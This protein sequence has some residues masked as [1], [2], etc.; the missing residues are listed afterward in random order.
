MNES[1]IIKTALASVPAPIA[2]MAALKP[3]PRKAAMAELI[4]MPVNGSGSA[5]NT[6]RPKNSRS[7]VRRLFRIARLAR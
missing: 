4:H 5:A 6:K 2:S 1:I 3:S 7:L